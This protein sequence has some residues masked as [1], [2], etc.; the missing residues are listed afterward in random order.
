MSGFQVCSFQTCSLEYMLCGSDLDR[1]TLRYHHLTQTVSGSSSHRRSLQLGAQCAETVCETRLCEIGRNLGHPLSKS[2]DWQRLWCHLFSAG[3]GQVS[4]VIR[5]L[6][7]R[8]SL[9][10]RQAFLFSLHVYRDFHKS[11][12]YSV[13]SLWD[14]DL[15]YLWSGFA[16]NR[17]PLMKVELFEFMFLNSK[18]LKA[19]A[20]NNVFTPAQA[21]FKPIRQENWLFR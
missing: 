16:M 3:Q 6:R 13:S 2:A 19:N 10:S 17:M 21:V 11:S 20:E 14:A 18:E 4:W 8:P 1:A 12:F 9:P 5:S 15:H 7:L